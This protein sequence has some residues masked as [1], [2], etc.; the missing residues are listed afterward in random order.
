MV[1]LGGEGS[2]RTTRNLIPWVREDFPEEGTIRGAGVSQ[3]CGG[4]NPPAAEI[5]E[6]S[7]PTKVAQRLSVDL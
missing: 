6:H 7:S 5:K 1:V 4:R 3:V 2:P